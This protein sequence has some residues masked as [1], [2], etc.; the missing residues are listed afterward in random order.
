[1]VFF[2]V[3]AI[4]TAGSSTRVVASEKTL[5]IGALMAVTG[6]WA[7]AYDNTILHMSEIAAEI[8]NEQ[9]GIK[10]KGD[11]YKIKLVVEDTKSD[12]NGV[13]S[14]ANKLIYDR[15]VKFIIGPSG[16]FVS[17]ATP[18]TEPAEVMMITGWHT[19]MPGEIDA[20]TPYTFATSKGSLTGDIAVIKSMRRDFP[21]L[22]RIALV[23]PDDGA[24][25]SLMPLV[26]NILAENGFTVVGDVI[27][28]SNT[29]EDFS[30]IVAKILSL[31]GVEAVFVERS[32]PPH[33]GAITKG[34]REGGNHM[35]VF[36]GSPNSTAEIATIAGAA[37]T[38]GVRTTIDTLNDP[39][40]PP[41]MAEMAK[42]F[43]ARYGKD[44][45]L[46]YQCAVGVFLFKTL[47]EKAQSLDPTKVKAQFESM[48]T[49]DTICGKGIICGE[50]SFGIKH[51]VAHPLPI[52]K[53]ENGKP[54][55]A[56]W[57]DIG[58]VP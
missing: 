12:F 32:A 51:L 15:G 18:V 11:T 52:Q 37:A 4:M 10:V 13:A 43:A 36:T 58:S 49:V 16:F 41:L 56:G 17:A 50:K 27:R 20:T 24:I 46:S 29:L 21:N 28:F 54:T 55:P 23:T 2:M 35:P 47:I 9:G 44:M 19:N 33:L 22:K 42:R 5:K 38:E 7:S 25:P 31:K 14:A 45:P 39:D 30:P 34:L 53:F 6:W 26:K 57:I 1:M 48:D 3:A 8:I 40:M